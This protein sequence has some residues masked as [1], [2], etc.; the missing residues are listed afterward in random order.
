MFMTF[1][2][3]KLNLYGLQLN[4]VICIGR[5][6]FYCNFMFSIKTIV[7]GGHLEKGSPF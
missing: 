6:Q 3:V 5:E 4:L 2:E 1:E 7:Y